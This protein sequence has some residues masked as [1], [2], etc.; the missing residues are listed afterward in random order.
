MDLMRRSPLKKIL[1]V[2]LGF[3]VAYW[4]LT[5]T[6]LHQH[7][8][9]ISYSSNYEHWG[10]TAP[11]LPLIQQLQGNVPPDI[12]PVNGY[13]Y[14]FLLRNDHKC[15]VTDSKDTIQLLFVI[16]SALQ[17]FNSRDVIRQTWGSETRFSDVMIKT[18]FLVGD[19]VDAPHMQ[20]R[21]RKESN[22]HKDIIQGSFIDSYYNNTIKTMM[23]QHWAYHNCA[24]AN[25][26]FF[27]DDDY[28][29]STR[30][31]LRFLKDPK[32][33][34]KY[35]QSFV[36]NAGIDQ[37]ANLYAGYVF[38]SSSPKRFVLSKWYVS[39]EEYPFSQ[40]PPYVTAGAY[41][42]SRKSL[43]TL[44]FAGLYTNFFR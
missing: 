41:V 15:D 38:P 37:Q 8:L 12:Q 27:V 36:A 26:F 39:L 6:G 9:A 17:N 21:L 2:F 19:E 35:L 3:Y 44:Y 43:E 10:P 5:L 29:V 22:S 14:K 18:V 40:Y 24:S 34:P 33:Y 13:K 42:L 32:N 25:Y 23:G 20:V 1:F 4:L 7:L 28:Y 11:L 30:N 31:M 16:K